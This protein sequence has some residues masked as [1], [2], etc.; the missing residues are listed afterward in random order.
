MRYLTNTL[1][2]TFP[3][4]ARERIWKIRQYLILYHNNKA[5]L[6]QGNRAMPQLF[7]PV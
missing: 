6:S 7:F 5:V 2:Q 3:T 1:L 4:C